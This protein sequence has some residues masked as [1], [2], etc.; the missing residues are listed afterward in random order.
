MEYRSQAVLSFCSQFGKAAYDS[1]GADLHFVKGFCDGA[2]FDHITGPNGSQLLFVTDV[3]HRG[4]CP[5]NL[6]DGDQVVVFNGREAATMTTTEVHEGVMPNPEVIAPP[7]M[8]LRRPR[9][10]VRSSVFK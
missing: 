1:H 7:L 9:E 2:S 5:E 10:C 4:S 3:F 8:I 6:H